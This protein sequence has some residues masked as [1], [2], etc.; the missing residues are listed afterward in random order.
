MDAHANFAYSTV[1]TAPVTATAGTSLVVA[2]GQGALFP[3][4]PFNAVI[5]PTSAQPIS[6]NSE[7]VRVTARSTDTLTITR[8]QE[9]TAARTVVV[10]DQIS[11]A[12]T[13]KTLT[14]IEPS[15]TTV[16]PA[17]NQNDYDL[18][19]G[20]FGRLTP[21]ASVVITGILA[22]SA[23]EEK[24]LVNLSTDKIVLLAH[25]NASST[26]ANR[27]DVSINGRGHIL[28]LPGDAIRLVYDGTSTRW[29]QCAQ[30]RIGSV[31]DGWLKRSGVAIPAGTVATFGVTLSQEVAATT[32]TPATGTYIGQ[33]SRV[34]MQTGA[35]SG[36]SAGIRNVASIAIGDAAG[37]GGFHIRTMFGGLTNP[38]DAGSSFIGVRGAATAIGN[39]DASSLTDILGVGTDPTQNTYRLLKND[40]SGTATASDLGSD[41]PWN[42]TACYDFRVFCPPNGAGIAWA[43][44]R[45]DDLTITPKVGYESSDIPSNSTMLAWH[46]HIGNR[47][48]S[49]AYAIDFMAL[50]IF[51]PN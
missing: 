27:L 7:I 4:V 16:S 36:S 23:G 8:A 37:R 10:G 11:A 48:A 15:T 50:E 22:G 31:L 5:W 32:R 25:E 29:R 14:D 43:I 21:S 40:A 45:T 33:V 3:A 38:A 18:S 12:V 47:A 1:A 20:K 6:T 17:A 44:W 42:A 13:K 30:S 2:A 19:A 46:A 41:F 9:D 28:L 34:G 26:A 24:T 51:Q 35:G 49:A 39:V